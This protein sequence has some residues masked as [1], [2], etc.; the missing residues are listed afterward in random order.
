MNFFRAK[1]AVKPAALPPFHPDTILRDLGDGDAF[2][3]G[4]ALTGTIILGG[5][6]SGKTS[7]PAKSLAHSFLSNG[8]GGLILTAKPDERPQWEKWIADCGRQKDLVI[9]NTEGDARFNFMDWEASRA[10]KG[11][12]YAI[13]IVALLDEIAEAIAGSGK[14]DGGGNSK[15]WED[16]LHTLNSNLVDLPLLAGLQVSLPLLR[17]IAS[18]A[19][20]SV[21]QVNDP[22]WQ[23]ESLCARILK[24]AD[25]ITKNGD[26]EA[27]ADFLEVKTYWTKDFPA[28]AEETRSS[29]MLNF[30]VLIRPL[31]TRPLRKIFSSDTNITPEATFD[32]K[33]IIVDL[34]V[35]EYKLAGR[36]CNLIWKHCLQSAV[37]RRVQPADRQSFL[38][39]VLLYADECQNFIVK[40]DTEFQAVAR[41]AGGVTCYIT[42]NRETL[43]RVLKNN[44]AVDSLLANLQTKFFCQ[45]TGGTNLWASEI[46]GQH[47]VNISSTNVGHSRQGQQLLAPNQVPNQ[48]SGV[49]RSQD[50]R[51][52]VEPAAFTI[53]K[54]GGPQ[55]NY[56]V[57][58]ICYKAGHLFGNGGGER[59]PYKLLTFNQR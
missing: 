54:K 2:T 45:N 28:L 34:P 6:G 59:L 43:R 55:F 31:V 15:F 44:D 25:E 13:N 42:Q 24:E 27:R 47:Y 9:V 18:S 57:E 51:F 5:T 32:G 12:G 21:E 40:G 22:D 1:S 52:F 39:P 53:L 56:Q 38:R 49:T 46:L 14:S 37:L 35:A 26:P 50:K 11:A 30:A 23:K 4:D 58:V 8:F 17:D 48:S 41:S 20:Q 36:I 7:G 33:I 16:C 10:G 29:I 19:A 3:L